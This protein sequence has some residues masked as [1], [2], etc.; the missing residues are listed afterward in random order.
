[1]NKL[2][3][4][5]GSLSL[6]LVLSACAPERSE[7]QG[8]ASSSDAASEGLLVWAPDIELSAIESQ[9]EAFTEETGIPVE[10]VSMPQDDQT[11]AIVLD[12]PSGNGPDLFYQPGV[13]N[14]SIQGLVHPVEVDQEILDT[15][16]AGSLE[17]LSYDGELYGLPAV[18]E[19]LALYYNKALIPEAPETVEDLEAA[20]ADLTDDANDQFGFLYPAN[21]FYFSYPF[22]AGYGGYIFNEDSDGYV[23]DDVGLANDGQYKAHL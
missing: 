8:T 18:V 22:M 9:V 17:A 14:L 3:L 10:V 6:V 4:T 13:G 11:E 5:A 1:M 7:D 2:K 12:G 23:K 15:Y 20:M 21:D 19:S 16:S